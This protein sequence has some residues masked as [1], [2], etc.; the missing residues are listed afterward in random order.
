[1]TPSPQ[2]QSTVV[3]ALG[4]SVLSGIRYFGDMA[5]LCAQIIKWTALGLCFRPSARFPLRATAEQMRK[6]G[7]R[8]LP[9]VVLVQ[10]SCGMIMALQM[11]PTLEPFGLESK[12]ANIVGVAGFRM[13]GPIFTAA[14]LAGFAGAAVAAEIGTMVVTEEIQ[15]MRAMAM[16]P[17]RHLVVP[18]V[19][20]TFLAM[21]L[22]TSIADI[23][24]A[25]GG[26]MVVRVILSPTAYGMY[27]RSMQDQIGMLDLV[28]GL[29]QGGL[30]GLMI[31][32][33]ACHEG[34]RVQTGAAGVG[35][36]T[37]MT[38][39]YSIVGILIAAGICTLIF[40]GFKL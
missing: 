21:L 38:V 29:I 5:F 13:L 4:A 26:Y 36:A 8:G 34:L 27:W 39:V 9:V 6:I 37:T 32:L 10:I 16:D 3:H 30:F 20:A 40:F 17:V 15:A 1:M 18:R 24:I 28:T 35:R 33:V 22:L 19:M 31:G 25:L 14:V 7:L 12:I 23:M 11:S 2:P